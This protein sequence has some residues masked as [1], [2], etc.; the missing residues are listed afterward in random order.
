MLAHIKKLLVLLK[1]E[2]EHKKYVEK[3]EKYENLLK[4]RIDELIADG[5]NDPQISKFLY[6]KNGTTVFINRVYGIL[7]QKRRVKQMA[8]QRNTKE[9]SR[10]F[11]PGT[12]VDGDLQLIL[13]EKGHKGPKGNQFPFY[14]FD[15]IN[16]DD[17][18]AMGW[19]TLRIG[20][21]RDVLKYACHIGFDVKPEY[22]GN[23]YAA[24]ATRL[25][26]EFAKQHGMAE[27]WIGCSDD[28]LPSIK[29]CERVGA[30]LV[31]TIDVPEGID[32]YDQGMRRLCRYCLK[33]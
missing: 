26:I 16:R 20:D 25:L 10:F 32:L 27:L 31:E 1:S 19:V 22:R 12:L 11:E 8:R 18:M 28:N 3:L 4:N 2:E 33:L 6:R 24:R 29:T 23:M 9:T 30:I 7:G 5:I 13:S 21:T 17:N 15:M 14:R